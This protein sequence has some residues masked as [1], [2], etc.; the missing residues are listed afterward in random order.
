MI[1]RIVRMVFEPDQVAAFEALFAQHK[2]QIRSVPGCLH[3]ELHRDAANPHVRYTY[4]HW[5]DQ[6]ALNAYRD[7]QLFGKV[8][9]KTKALF[10]DKP[11]AFSLVHQETVNLP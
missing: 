2:H 3:L 4:S 5:T 6:D 7:S 8:W 10:A 1:V 11:T 9:P